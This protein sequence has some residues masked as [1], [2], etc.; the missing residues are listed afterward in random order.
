MWV[1]YWVHLLIPLALAAGTVLTWPRTGHPGHTVELAL[2]GSIAWLMAGIAFYFWG[3]RSVRIAAA[4]SSYLL[5]VFSTLLAVGALELSVRLF[6]R[7]Q[8]AE[9]FP[10][11][12][13]QVFT[14]TTTEHI[15]PGLEGKKTFTTDEF[16]LRGP[17]FPRGGK[18]YKIVTVGGSTTECLYLDDSEEWSH[19]LMDDLNAG[20]GSRAWVANAGVAAHTT[21]HHLRLMQTLPV[22]SRI[23][24]AI[25]LTGINDMIYTLAYEGAA[26][27]TQIEA[28]TKLTLETGAG[29]WFGRSKVYQM[30]SGYLAS[31][32]APPKRNDDATLPNFY[33][34][35]RVT[36]KQGK[37]VPIPNID[38]GLAE[39]HQRIL[40][41][42]AQC[43]TLGI[44]CLFMTQ[45]TM[46]REGLSPAETD[47]LWFGWVGMQERSRF[48]S[49]SELEIAM[50]RYNQVLLDT[51]HQAG[52]VS[53]SGIRHPQEYRSIL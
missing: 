26:T 12:A 35:R 43:R 28:R 21:V 8:H 5:I 30:I 9:Y 49:V 25:F 41:L 24:L 42:A 14:L 38:T 39:Y 23:N 48:A 40:R 11:P 32:H 20:A 31:R 1:W 19:V 45:P 7:A 4:V 36:R 10:R 44:R 52:A 17:A 16:G 6:L 13:N 15:T 27:Q 2:A 18:V 34:D 33:W 51:C 53:G 29:P 47:L 22:F 46:W 37:I 50:A 3:R